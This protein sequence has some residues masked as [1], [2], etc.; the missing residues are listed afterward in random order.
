MSGGGQVSW[1]RNAQRKCM[2]CQTPSYDIRQWPMVLQPGLEP[3]WNTE[4]VLWSDPSVHLLHHWRPKLWA[5]NLCEHILHSS[6][7]TGWFVSMSLC[8]WHPEKYLWLVWEEHCFIISCR[9]GRWDVNS[10]LPANSFP[11]YTVLRWHPSSGLVI[12]AALGLLHGLS[13]E[14][15]RLQFWEVTV[16]LLFQAKWNL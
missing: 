15:P 1:G 13:I 7:A 12:A 3:R 6:T 10:Y 14:E 9:T 11:A 5:Y 8:F 2:C 16:L 4:S